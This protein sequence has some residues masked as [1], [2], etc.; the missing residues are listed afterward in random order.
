MTKGVLVVGDP[1]GFV[2]P[3]HKGTAGLGPL[4]PD[5]S[6]WGLLMH[7]GLCVSVEGVP[8]GLV[9]QKVWSRTPGAVAS[10]PSRSKRKTSEKESNKWL[11]AQQA[12]RERL[13]GVEFISV[14]DREA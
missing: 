3:S 2:F 5:P 4:S 9:W 6:R 7:S 13:G 12:A 11:E 1:S 10:G 14:C 8:L